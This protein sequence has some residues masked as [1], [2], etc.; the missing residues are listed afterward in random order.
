MVQCKLI[1]NKSVICDIIITCVWCPQH[2][3]I[4]CICTY[5]L[6][7]GNVQCIVMLF[8]QSPLH[9]HP[10]SLSNISN[11]LSLSHS[12]NEIN[13]IIVIL[14]TTI[15]DVYGDIRLSLLI[16]RLTIEYIIILYLGLKNITIA[17]ENESA[18]LPT[19]SHIGTTIYNLIKNNNN[20]I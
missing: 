5:V 11:F 12:S 9:R 15:Q 19:C 8:F 7:V 17:Y 14:Y 1:R 18:A 13:R 20:I 4:L 2:E 10:H 16:A 6:I 3:Y